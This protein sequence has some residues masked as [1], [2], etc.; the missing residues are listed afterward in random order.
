LEFRTAS[1]AFNYDPVAKEAQYLRAIHL[2]GAKSIGVTLPETSADGIV[3][4]HSARLPSDLFA[5]DWFVNGEL[6]SD[7]SA[8]G[9]S[10]SDGAATDDFV[11][12]VTFPRPSSTTETS[13]A[14][15]I[16]DLNGEPVIE[17]KDV[18][19]DFADVYG[20][21]F[22]FEG[23]FYFVPRPIRTGRVSLSST[24]TS[25]STLICLTAQSFTMRPAALPCSSVI[26]TSRTLLSDRAPAHKS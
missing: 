26:L 25:R 21:R 1:D 10:L 5:I 9:A 16:R 6:V 2:Q 20:G 22:S 15:R 23:G 13:I 11:Q 19:D 17:V 12:K 24:A 4:T 8:Y 7:W 3:V 14:Y 18:L